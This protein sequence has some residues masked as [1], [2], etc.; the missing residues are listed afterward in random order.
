MI[1]LCK[2]C[3]WRCKVVLYDGNKIMNS[4]QC[5]YR[6]D[7]CMEIDPHD[8]DTESC[9]FFELRN[10]LKKDNPFS[11]AIKYIKEKKKNK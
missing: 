10:S 2:K 3:I 6:I 5:Y 4:N 8:D 7:A 11:E 9:R 1:D